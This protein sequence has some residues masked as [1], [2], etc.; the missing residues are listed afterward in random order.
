MRRP[1]RVT[2]S[3]SCPSTGPACVEQR[4]DLAL[5]RG[6]VELELDRGGGAAE[7]VEVVDQ[8]ERLA[9]VEADHLEGAVAAVEAVVLQRRPSPRRSGSIVPSTLAS[10]VKPAVTAARLPE[11]APPLPASGLDRGSARGGRS[12]RQRGA[13]PADHGSCCPRRPCCSRSDVEDGDGAEV[14]LRPV[15]PGEF[16]SGRRAGSAVRSRP[17]MPLAA[18]EELAEGVEQGVPDEALGAFGS[19]SPAAAAFTRRRPGRRFRSRR[20]IPRPR[21]RRVDAGEACSAA[22]CC[23]RGR[24]CW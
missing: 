11:T 19:S 15:E 13:D 8:R 20:S 24:R 6:A 9:V 22:W 12:A 21:W 3:R 23:S 4:V 18:G 5:Q 7:P 1:P 14:D 17:A 10:S 2:I 16:A